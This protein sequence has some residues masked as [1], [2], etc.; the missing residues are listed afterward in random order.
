MPINTLDYDEYANAV[1]VE[2]LNNGEKAYAVYSVAKNQYVNNKLYAFACYMRQKNAIAMVSDKSERMTDS[3]LNLT[4]QGS[5][6][7]MDLFYK[8]GYIIVK[9]VQVL[10]IVKVK[11]H[12]KESL[13]IQIEVN[14]HKKKY[15]E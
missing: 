6:Y 14:K 8:Y 2:V 10:R 7:M 1:I 12:I 11:A 4:K 13:N 15:R 9:L 3:S 5:D